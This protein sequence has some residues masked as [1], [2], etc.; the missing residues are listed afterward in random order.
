MSSKDIDSS[1]DNLKAEK[2]RRS[3]TSSPMSDDEFLEKHAALLAEKEKVSAY[4]AFRD[5]LSQIMKR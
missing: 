5:D 2:I 4:N 1:I 3:K